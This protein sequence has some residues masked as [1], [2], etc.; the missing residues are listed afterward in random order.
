MAGIYIHI[1]FCKQKCHYCNFYSSVSNNQK[2]EF[3][4]S[5]QVEID[6]QKDYLLGEEIMTVY[7]GGGTPSLLK[8]AEIEHIVQKL[9]NTFFISNNAEYTLEVNP[10]DLSE[11][12]SKELIDAG[13]NRLSIGVQSFHDEDLKYLNRV[14]SATQAH[15]AIEGALKNGFTN[16]TIDL[17]Y[18]IPTLNPENWIKNLNRF[19]NYRLP[20]LSAYALTV[21]PKT[22]LHVLITKNK[23]A[24]IDEQ[25]MVD[26]FRIL[27]EL[28][29]AHDFIHYE[30]SNFSKA[31][32]NSKHNSLYWLGGNYLGLGPSAHS[33]NGISRQWNYSSLSKYL[34]LDDLKTVVYEKEILTTQQKYNEYVM[35]S[36]RTSWGCNLDYISTV[37]GEEFQQH[38][39]N[40]ARPYLDSKKLKM[41]GNILRLTDDGKL[42]ADGI[43][44]DLFY[45]D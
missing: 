6:Q 1:P 36:I 29:K 2:D 35:T 38:C 42:F 30:I 44:A 27:L 19:F 8:R 34:K 18:G 4:K 39:K 24:G 25:N 28:T 17:I 9:K 10:D 21:E 31:G 22:P 14:H 5:L 23:I 20:H 33:Y 3:L 11:D 7:F 37:F 43:T 26:H 13:I 40:S 45:E 16:L 12:K 32:Y 15:L 41:N